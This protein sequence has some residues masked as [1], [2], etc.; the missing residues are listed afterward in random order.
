MRITRLDLLAYGAF[1]ARALDFPPGSPD[2]HIVV[3][4]NEAGKSTIRQAIGDLLFGFPHVTRHAFMHEERALRIG[5]TLLSAEREIAV[6]RRKGRKDTLLSPQGEALSDRILGA[7]LLGRDRS[8][9]ERMFSLDEAAL[10]AGGQAILENRDDVS[11]MIFAAS[12]GAAGFGRQIALLDAQAD[13][14][15]SLRKSTK[16]SFHV[17]AERFEAAT[18]ELRQRAVRSGDLKTRRDQLARAEARVDELTTTM[19]THAALLRRLQRIQRTASDLRL[20]GDR[21]RERAELGSVPTLPGD[22]KAR[23]DRIED[24]LAKLGGSIGS[25]DADLRDAEAARGGVSVDAAILAEEQEILRLDRL[26]AVTANHPFDIEKRNGEIE[27]LVRSCLEKAARNGISAESADT[28]VARLPN[29]LVLAELEEIG[30]EH[31]K[32]AAACESARERIAARKEDARRL[33]EASARLQAG[34]V[35][36]GL[37]AAIDTARGLGEAIGRR[38]ELAR[39][40]EA[41]RV[42]SE[43]SLAA[44]PG[45]SG[46]HAQLDDLRPPSAAES[47]DAARDL[48]QADDAERR[49]ASRLDEEERRWTELDAAEKAIRAE[50]RAVSVDAIDAA[51]RARDE[52][53]AQLRARL[54][55]APIPGPAPSPV[56]AV[57]GM[58]AAMRAADALADQRFETVQESTRLAEIRRMMRESAGRR[59]AAKTTAATS[60][61]RAAELREAW[62]TRLTAGGIPPMSPEELRGWL[63]ARILASRAAREAARERGALEAFDGRVADATGAL[64]RELEALG[65]RPAPELRIDALLG[66]AERLLAAATDATR[67]HALH[68]EQIRAIEQDLVRLT[69]RLVDSETR[70]RDHRERWEALIGRAGLPPLLGTELVRGFVQIVREL[71]ADLVGHEDLKRRIAGMRRDLENLDAGVGAACARL[72]PDLAS[73]P[74]RQACSALANRLEAAKKASD[75]LKALAERIAGLNARR[76]QAVAQR[77]EALATLAPMH[78]SAGT[79][80]LVALREVID[81][82]TRARTIADEIAAAEARLRGSGDGLE[83]AELQAEQRAAAIDRLPFEITEAERESARLSHLRDQAITDLAAARRHLEEVSGGD[84]VAEVES[85]RQAALAAMGDAVSNYLEARVPARLLRWA[86]DRYRQEK[87]APLLRRAG[88]IFASLTG[89]SFSGLDVEMDDDRP[90]LMGLRANGRAV[91]LPGMSHGTEDQ[92]YLAMRLAALEDHLARQPA[93]PF[94]ADDL[95]VQF[96]DRRA[97][98]GFAALGQLARRTQVIFFTHHEHLIALAQEALGGGVDVVRL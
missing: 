43:D 15:W 61:R 51:R 47:D 40:A 96:D 94:I 60:A 13:T 84:L 46:S 7:F 10:R 71:R 14:Q 92:L 21:N 6:Q 50:G 2:L 26:A 58:A 97:C 57:E 66:E 17:A 37:K 8:F 49:A 68:G 73:L 70:I 98:A 34:E 78:A 63:Q 62:R 75:R 87:Q 11:A 90:R 1:T 4:A 25:I 32:L 45:W 95:F 52:I 81:R 74:A 5:A 65:R 93:L 19:G 41:A 67:Q 48:A 23:L 59:E 24:I 18:R 30:E 12:A 79:S 36:Q 38:A 77:D 83:I 64:R 56:E 3:G 16:R 27:V 76:E 44:L 35:P 69:Q 39:K 72:A 89:G 28:L 53:W 42:A 91:D 31:V 54:L 29:E 55:G 88:E 85:Q 86:M 82:A 22:A 80:D 20:L 9:F 33:E